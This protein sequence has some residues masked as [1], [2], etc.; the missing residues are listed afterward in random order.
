M[1]ELFPVGGGLVIGLLVG[2]LRPSL[3][4]GVAVLLSVVFGVVATVVSG[5]F[6]ISWGYLLVDIPLV[7]GSAG[8]SFLVTRAVR[9][10]LS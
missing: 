3:R 5:E 1:S 7:A 8:L 4:V 2:L 9:R 10:S 6:R